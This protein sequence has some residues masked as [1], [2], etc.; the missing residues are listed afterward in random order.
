M[1]KYIND[2]VSDFEKEL[3]I[4]LMNKEADMPLVEYVKDA[5]RSLEIVKNIKIL[6]FEYNE[7]E[8]EI[9]INRFIF[10]REKKKRK[11][12]R[13]DY[14]FVNDDRYG[15]LTV[16]IQ[17]TIE[18][19]DQRTKEKS[20]HQKIIKKQMLIPLQDEEGY[21]YIK[22][23]K[24][25]IIYQLV[26][27][28]TYTSSSSVTLKSL[29][30][31][32]VKRNSIKTENFTKTVINKTD[33]NGT[34]Y[35]LPVYNVFVFK[36]EIPIILFFVAN[37]LDWALSFLGVDTVIKFIEDTDNI[38][39][40]KNIYFQV[41]SKL[42]IEVNKELFL[43]YPYIQGIV[44]MFL[45]VCTNR[46]TLKDM[47]NKEIWIKKLSNNNTLEK[48]NDILVFFNRLMDETTKKILMLDDFNKKDVYALLRWIMQNY[49]TL[50]MKDNLSLDNKRLRCNE[51]VA[52]LLTQEFS[53]RLNRIITLG[54]K[55][56]MGDF[57]DCFK[58]SGEILIQKMH[59]SGI[60]RFDDTINDLDFFSKFKYTT[61]GPHSL[62]G[63]NSNNISIRYRGIH[64]S[65]LGNID[66]LV[67]GNSDPGTSGILS[68]FGKIEGLYFNNSSEPDDFTFDFKKDIKN[69]MD[70]DDV[71]YL[72][73]NCD[74][75]KDYYKILNAL[76]DFNEDSITVS[77]TSKDNFK[78]IVE[79]SEDAD[80]DENDTDDDALDDENL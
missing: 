1:K 17:I 66:L 18:E 15:C 28:S 24:Y 31:I 42:F 76:V 62:G 4:P 48:G 74:N 40:E 14:K 64:P 21:Y 69:I 67:C 56:T 59:S 5:W 43:K 29:M 70:K 54:S 53:K 63:K 55:A 78:I 23:K 80:S 46:F 26:D 73:I 19:E 58:F 3:N 45:E 41:S 77:G 49:N 36:K 35:L 71:E 75:K 20:I 37:G 9:D 6:K 13:C 72:E 65:F 16:H 30:P 47:Y 57:H 10:K 61:K 25:Y 8:S 51:Y 32:A 38:D 44:G 7:N 12:D 34:E 68:P 52:S 33:D 22:G 11:K 79:N 2:Y 60:L 39:E 27:K 50:R